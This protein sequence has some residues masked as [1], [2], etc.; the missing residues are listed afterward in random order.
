MNRWISSSPSRNR[1]FEIRSV[2]PTKQDKSQD[3]SCFRIYTFEEDTFGLL[4][5]FFCGSTYG[6]NSMRGL[7]SFDL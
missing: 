1:R 2:W 5:Q 7:A 3:L 4:Y 6:H